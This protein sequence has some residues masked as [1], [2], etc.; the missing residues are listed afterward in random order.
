M[1]SGGV[2]AQWGAPAPPLFPLA[3]ASLVTRYQ[4]DA[5][6]PTTRPH[7]SRPYGTML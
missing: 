1:V 4:V 5:S 3:T 6:V 2:E 7:L